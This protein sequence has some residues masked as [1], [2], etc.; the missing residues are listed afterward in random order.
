MLKRHAW[1][2]TRD[3]EGTTSSPLRIRLLTRLAPIAALAV[4]LPTAAKANIDIVYNPTNFVANQPSTLSIDGVITQG[5]TSTGI[6]AAT[7]KLRFDPA[8]VTLSN[9]HAPPSSGWSV[10]AYNLDHAADGWAIAIV[11]NNL[12][13]GQ[14]VNGPMLLF[15]A[16]PADATVVVN[17]CVTLKMSALESDMADQV[18]NS[19]YPS[20]PCGGPL[21]PVVDPPATPSGGGGPAGPSFS[22]PIDC[23]IANAR[24][25]LRI[26]GGLLVAA[27][28][29]VW[30]LDYDS[31]GRITILDAELALRAP[32]GTPADVEAAATGAD[33]L[34][35]PKIV[36]YWTPVTGATS[37]AVY[38]RDEGQSSAHLMATIA[39]SDT[40]LSYPGSGYLWYKDVDPTKVDGTEY[41][42]SV[43]PANAYASAPPSQEVAALANLSEVPWDTVSWD[44]SDQ[45][46]AIWLILYRFVT[47][48]PA[49]D[50]P[51][52]LPNPITITGPDGLN[53]DCSYDDVNAQWQYSVYGPQGSY[54]A[55]TNTYTRSNGESFQIPFDGMTVETGGL[56]PDRVPDEI[57]DPKAKG[58]YRR[59]LSKDVGN[60]VGVSTVVHLPIASPGNTN[61]VRTTEGNTPFVYLGHAGYVGGQPYEACDAGLMFNTGAQTHNWSLYLHG[62][63]PKDWTEPPHARISTAAEVKY[64][65][66][67]WSTGGHRLGGL[68][69][70]LV[71]HEDLSFELVDALGRFLPYRSRSI[72]RKMKRLVTIAQTAT[73]VT[74]L[75]HD[76]LISDVGMM[77]NTLYWSDGSSGNWTSSETGED[78]AHTLGIAT[79]EVSGT[80][81]NEYPIRLYLPAL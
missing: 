65:T 51:Y 29:D 8:K 35:N 53:Y 37:Y 77:G 9:L 73:G 36:V 27:T 5:G 22:Q 61:Y 59:V 47:G 78:G 55:A 62:S 38:R 12:D 19:V 14:T 21:V 68:L 1:S 71:T 13:F 44:G 42:Y 56:A 46:S 60:P 43:R 24:Q 6:V 63:K 4:F 74:P 33:D 50:A 39:Q 10:M 49:L 58:P 75:A 57:L 67:S 45:S 23:Q 81:T 54:D 40:N 18:C 80:L 15:T 76:T 25:A 79:V 32:C 17:D 2:A 31:D 26:A 64:V 72:S 3:S 34:G 16:T 69:T 70:A 41:Y 52:S 11:Y 30:N 66:L 48:V 28:A 20:D 7:I